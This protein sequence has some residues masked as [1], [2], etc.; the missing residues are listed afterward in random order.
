[1]AFA[2]FLLIFK[3][4]LPCSDASSSNDSSKLG[5]LRRIGVELAIGLGMDDISLVMPKVSKNG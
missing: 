3:P 5:S 4:Y 1:M 2:H